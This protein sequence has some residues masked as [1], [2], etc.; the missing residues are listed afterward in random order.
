[1]STERDERT[2]AGL[3]QSRSEGL[4]ILGYD[5]SWQLRSENVVTAAAV[6]MDDIMCAGVK[7]VITTV[8]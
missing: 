1:M 3:R 7:K 8:R 5:A 2:R 4:P 6:N